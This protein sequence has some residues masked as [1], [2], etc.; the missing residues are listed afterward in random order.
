MGMALT[1]AEAPFVFEGSVK[2]TSTSNVSAVP[3][4]ARTAVVQV[5]HVRQAPRALAGL[6]GKEI[7]VRM[8]S[9]EAL[10]TGEKAVFFADA[11]VFG[12]HLA[13][14]SLGHDPIVAMEAKAALAGADPVVQRLRRRIDEAHTVVS[15]RVTAVRAPAR[16]KASARATSGGRI[17][18]HAPLWQD[19]VVDVSGVFKGPTQKKVVVR[20]PSS[21]DVR[22]RNAPHFKKGQQGTW[23]L[24]P[25]A[26]T[27][28]TGKA[29]AAV[30]GPARAPSSYY[31]ALDPNDFHPAAQASVVQAML[32]A[33]QSPRSR[34]AKK[35]V[36]RRGVTK[37][38]AMRKAGQPAK[39]HAKARKSARISGRK[40]RS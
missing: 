16:A 17:S 34:G 5:D 22:W 14:Q 18:E 30:A 26:P 15:G 32:P 40:R 9:N 1:K 28:V 37:K 24:Q 13:V 3:A 25:A 11:L 21:T 29:T 6:A 23:L 36:T 7:T 4:D 10:S 27:P 12:H 31:T 19:A 33:A 8:G 20:F 39:S 35:L 2:S 38:S